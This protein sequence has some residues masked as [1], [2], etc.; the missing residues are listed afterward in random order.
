VEA[1]PKLIM[2]LVGLVLVVALLLAIIKLVVFLLPAIIV[3]A[4][5]YLITRDEGKTAFAFL[6]AAAATILARLL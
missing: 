5:V 3:A 4:A 6:I 1:I 2:L